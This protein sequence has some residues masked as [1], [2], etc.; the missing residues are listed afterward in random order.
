[1]Y[2][3]SCQGG[4]GSQGIPPKSSPM[5]SKL[6]GRADFLIAKK[7]PY[8]HSPTQ[9]FGQRNDIRL[10]PIIVLGKPMACSSQPALNFIKDE[11]YAFIVAQ[12]SKIL[13]VLLIGG[14][15]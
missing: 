10:Y 12:K 2:L 4:S 1:D 5:V 3:Q 15:N 13:Q 14:Y 7:S 8:G 9:T 6:N 11:Q